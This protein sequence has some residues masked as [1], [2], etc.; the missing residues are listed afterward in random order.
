[1]EHSHKLAI[2]RSL[3]SMDQ[4]QMDLVLRYIHGLLKPSDD[5]SGIKQQ[6][7]KEIRKALR[8]EKKIQ[9]TA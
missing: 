8:M 9:A 6:A 7:M 4:T 3:E 1:M 2:Q 5:H